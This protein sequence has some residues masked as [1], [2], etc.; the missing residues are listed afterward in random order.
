M[1]AISRHGIWGCE[2]PARK[3]RM[4]DFEAVSDPID[5]AEQLVLAHARM[6][7]AREMKHDFGLDARFGEAHQSKCLIEGCQIL[8]RAVEHVVPDRPGDAISTPDGTVREANLA[9]DRILTACSAHVANLC[10][11]IVS[12][13][14]IECGIAGRKR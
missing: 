10:G 3:Y 9:A 4:H 14:H 13:R 6:R 2:C 11:D 12:F 5:T 1:D 7:R 8:D